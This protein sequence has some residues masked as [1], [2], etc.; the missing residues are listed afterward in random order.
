[1]TAVLPR[2]TFTATIVAVGPPD[3]TREAREVLQALAARTAVRNIL[4]T[5][6]DDPEPEIVTDGDVVTIEGLVPRYLNNAVARLR[7]SSMPSLAWWRGGER[8]QLES[9]AG[10]V[11][12]V[13]FD[14]VD[15]TSDWT[16]AGAIAPTTTIS[17][18][19]RTRLTRWRSLLAQ[20]FDIPDARTDG[21]VFSSLEVRA[22]DTWS[23]RL[24]GGWVA[25]RL[26]NGDSL[27]VNVVDVPD[28]AP[29][30]S[31]SLAG[32]DIRLVLRLL[33][34]SRCIESSVEKS[35]EVLASRVGHAGSD[36]LE[37]LL[38][39][40]L[41]IRSR[42]VAFEDALRDAKVRDSSWAHRLHGE[43]RSSR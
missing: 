35:G 15:P 33:A 6:G 8:E 12:R 7:V 16:V 38:G 40:E 4:I 26:P 39:E 2:R 9:L 32:N 36:S 31:I 43:P 22:G 25:S 41:R 11:D 17:D 34:N 27:Q 18:H 10:L 29:I 19:R 37:R 42:D 5:L 14:S 24:F 13:V 21:T 1:M 30:E 28:G 20:F 23:A 3:R